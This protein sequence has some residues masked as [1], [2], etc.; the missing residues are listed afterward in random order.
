[1]YRKKI[2]AQAFD[3]MQNFYGTVQEPRI[4]CYV[5]FHDHIS[6]TSLKKA[7]QLSVGAIPELTCVFDKKRHC[8]EKRPFTAED[9]FCLINIS[10]EGESSRFPYL[11]TAIEPTC[12]PQIKILLLRDERHDTL[13]LIINHMVSDGAGFKQYLYLLCDLYSKCEKDAKFSKSPEPL[14]RRNLNQLLKNLSFKE[15]LAILFSKS[16]Y[17]KPDPA[18]VL[19]LTGDSSHPII[20]RTQIEKEQF[21][22]IRHFTNDC[23][24]SVN[25]M[26]L[27]AYIRVLHQITGCKKITVPCP[28]DLRKY[29]KEGQQ[30]GIC[31]LTGNYWCDTE[32]A[33]GEIFSET[34]QK[35]SGQM[36]SQKQ[37]NDCLKGPMLFH[38]LFH[39]LPFSAVQ[40]SFLR[41]S[42]VPV[43][44]YSNLGILDNERLCFGGH[45]IEDAFISTA[46]KKV[47]YFQLSVSTYQGRCTL[48]SSL[49]GSEEDRKL[50]SGVLN[51]IVQEIRLNFA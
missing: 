15:K 42:P 43:T 39:I 12:E 32:I 27:T 9:M 17:G 23:H 29:K 21:N 3:C 37:S 8:W 16:N 41:I 49:Y 7:V 25:D 10:G 14:G 36:R 22:A 6:E 5:R 40:K 31:N 18:I 13:C 48:T 19:P 34:L 20:C 24:V 35:V 28:V 45:E 11:L 4:R 2:K 51:Q 46:V 38:M 33:P 30:C 50:V 26:I 47:P 44:S 1:M